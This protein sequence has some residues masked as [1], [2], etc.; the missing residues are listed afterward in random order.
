M[1]A[2]CSHGAQNAF[3]IRFI[4]S[5]RSPWRITLT[6]RPPPRSVAVDS[7]PP[8]LPT[9]VVHV[10]IFRSVRLAPGVSYPKRSLCSAI[11]SP[12][13]HESE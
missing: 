10:S 3:S 9:P 5:I 13:S 1:S 7:Q 8:S 2:S 12:K 4:S 11:E 6:R